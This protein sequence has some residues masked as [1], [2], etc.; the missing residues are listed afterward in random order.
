MRVSFKFIAWLWLGLILILGGLFYNAYSN[1]NPEAFLSLI[2]EQVQK[3]YP[4]TKLSIGKMDTKLS[5]DFNLRFKDVQL[6]RD[7]DVLGKVEEVELKVPWWLLLFNRGNAQ[8]LISHLEI[9]VDNDGKQSFMVPTMTSSSDKKDVVI[10]LPTYLSGA[11]YTIKAKDVSVKDIHTGRRYFAFSK[12]LVREFRDQKNSA[13]EMT[14]PI[15]LTHKG[16][17]YDVELWLFGDVTPQREIWRL[18]YRGEF[19]LNDS[20]DKFNLE[21]LL[22][23]GKAE[24]HPDKLDVSSSL[25]IL[26]ENEVVGEGTLATN[27]SDMNVFLKFE[28][29][30][31][32]YLQIVGEEMQNHYWEDLEGIANGEVSFSKNI[33]TGLTKLRGKMNFSG[34][35]ELSPG[36]AFDGK[37]SLSVQDR[38]WEASFF[39]PKGEV[40]MFRRAIVDF[41]KGKVAQYSQEFGFN[42]IEMAKVIH[43]IMGLYDFKKLEDKNYFVT[44]ITYKKCFDGDRVVNGNFRYGISLDQRHYLGEITDGKSS[45]T[46]NYQ[47]KA[48]AESLD[49][50]AVQFSWIPGL[51]IFEP[52][53]SANGAI[54]NGKLQGRWD[55]VFLNGNGLVQ[56]RVERLQNASGEWISFM[57]KIWKVF[58]VDSLS[59]ADQTWDYV[60]N[61]GVLKVNS[62]LIS[63]D[64]AKIM[65]SLSK[66]PTFKSHL[67]L[68]YPKNKKWRPVK[69]EVTEPIFA[70]EP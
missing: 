39:S 50:T 18:N 42:G 63:D 55:N 5:V 32:D 10:Q 13:F 27:D 51:K 65:G 26:F 38:K 44:T 31:Q 52:Y 4:G 64:T 9:F 2:N 35:L 22:V 67:I 40:S 14:I 53:F 49:A 59:V 34:N 46:I 66:D 15:S 8:I 43:P 48:N 16:N 69:K 21:D 61:K 24:F 28:K 23:D 1:F 17:N 12:V 70:K 11:L 29:L 19:R 30:N 47:N 25:N 33:K 3:N 60:L 36:N 45:L 68:S 56:G 57:D 7:E 41:D 62:T 20:V 37:W 54:L 6:V 58:S